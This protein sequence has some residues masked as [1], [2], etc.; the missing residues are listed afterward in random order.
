MR[1]LLSISTATFLAGCA[2]AATLATAGCGG[3]GSGSGGG[4]AGGTGASANGVVSGPADAHCTAT[5]TVDPNA[6]TAMGGA[7]GAGG[8]IE[9]PYSV[10]YNAEGDDDDCK[11]H[12]KWSIMETVAQ[13]TD[14]NFMLEIT[15]K[16]DG[17]PVTGAAP[18]IEAFLDET[19]PAPNSAQMAMEETG[20]MYHVGP[21]QLDKAG[22]WTARFH[23]FE[24]CADSEA[25][26]HGHVGFY[27]NVP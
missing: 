3:D 4:G 24:D 20:G 19:H 22:K 21:V 18:N 2:L 9:E 6:C 26:P 14:L 11:Y 17:K 10:L 25:S 7:G 23:F 16:S 12:V 15:T 1:S 27:V 8:A 5:V 13:N